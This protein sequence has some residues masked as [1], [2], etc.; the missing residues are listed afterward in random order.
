[1]IKG[2]LF[3][4]DGTLANTNPLILRTLRETFATMLPQRPLSEAEILEC[5]GPTL[6]ETGLIYF[7]DNPQAF[8]DHY[9]HLNLLY[10]DSMVEP[11]PGII[12]MLDSLKAMGMPMAVVSSKKRDVVERGLRLLGMADYFDFVLGGDEVENPKPHPE[13]IEVALSALGLAPDE[14]LMVGDNYHDIHAAQNA[15]V[16]SV[17]VGWAHRGPEYLA[18]FHPTY[19]IAAPQELVEIVTHSRVGAQ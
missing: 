10:H 7:P 1:M 15:G 16:A 9:R 19:L 17:A 18:Q 3:D 5:I 11:Y 14:A 13:P 2:I 12:E 4:F 6:H 8:V